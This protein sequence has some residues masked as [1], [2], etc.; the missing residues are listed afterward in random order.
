VNKNLDNKEETA[1][2]RAK[3][4]QN[5]EEPQKRGRTAKTMWHNRKVTVN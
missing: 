1:H 3:Q 5:T 4:K 2:R